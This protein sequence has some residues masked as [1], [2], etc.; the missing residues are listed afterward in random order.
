MLFVKLRPQSYKITW[1]TT[2]SQFST[3]QKIW[4]TL[5]TVR[6]CPYFPVDVVV[7]AAVIA[8]LV[9]VS[10]EPVDDFLVLTPLTVL[11]S[12][13]ADVLSGG[14]KTLV[15]TINKNVK[16]TTNKSYL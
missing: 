7:T 11:L 15:F 12:I 5:K 6:L 4:K 16:N 9:S 14:G 8:I 2:E 1:L 3:V 10:R 13:T